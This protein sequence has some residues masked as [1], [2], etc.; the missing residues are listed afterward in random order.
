MKRKH[1]CGIYKIENLINHKV[2]IGQSIDI[3]R[4]FRNHIN[5]E[6]S[7][8]LKRAFEKY[9]IENFSFEIIKE[10][11]DLD[12]W[13]IFLIQIYKATDKRYGYNSDFGGNARKVCSEEHK[14]KISKANMG[15]KFTKEHKEKLSLAKKGKS[16][17]FKGK[18]MSEE[19]R[20]KLS[21]SHKGQKPHKWSEES[22]LKLA[23]SKSGENSPNFIGYIICL[24]N[25]EIHSRTEWCELGYHID[26]KTHL[27]RRIKCKGKRFM[28]KS[29]YDEGVEWVEEIVVRKNPPKLTEEQHIRRRK[30]LNRSPMIVCLET[31][32]IHTSGDW[33]RLGYR[34]AIRVVNGHQTTT[35]GL[36]FKFVTDLQGNY[37]YNEEIA[38]RVIK[39]QTN[40]FFY[41]EKP[42]EKAI[43]EV[44]SGKKSK[45]PYIVCLETKEVHTIGEWS[46]CGYWNVYEVIKNKQENNK[47]LHFKYVTDLEGNFAYYE[48]DAIKYVANQTE[49]F[50]KIKEVV[51]SKPLFLCLET[52]EFKTFAEWFKLGYHHIN[53]VA[54][55]KR[56]S[57]KGLHFEFIKDKNGNY[58]CDEETAL[59]IINN[60]IVDTINS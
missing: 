27:K 32:E 3:E 45:S 8:H 29:E 35:K 59:K 44:H 21:L 9:G 50:F 4:R 2:Y 33:D 55:G 24:D 26:T 17:T 56:K 48:D 34:K 22:K 7:P 43:K 23:L 5:N 38:K 57:D 39:E 53:S 1:T 42:K 52:N 14:Q 36:H 18:K 49:E 13:E 51:K 30:L 37:V 11:K 19:S 54:E 58:I 25:L 16:S 47:G 31:K 46:K 60:N 20:R 28:F 6:V 12:Y 15:R 10:T 40:D 41:F